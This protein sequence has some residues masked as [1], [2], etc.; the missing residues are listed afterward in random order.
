MMEKLSVHTGPLHVKVD[1]MCTQSDE[2]ETK[3]HHTL[4]DFNTN[5]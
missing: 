5:Q 4:H 3:N 1:P 2:S